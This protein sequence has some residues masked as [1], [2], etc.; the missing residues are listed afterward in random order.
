MADRDYYEL[1]GVERSATPEEIK[2]AY[3]KLALQYHPDR[4]PGN[5]EAEAK[6]KE[7][8]EAYEVLSD[9]EKRRRY[10]QFGHEGV[11]SSFGPGGFDFQRDFSHFDDLQEILG[12]LFGG[13]G[14]LFEEMFQSAGRRRTTRNGPQPGSDLQFEMDIDLEEALFGSKREVTLPMEE[15]CSRC[16]GTGVEPGS[17]VEICRRC[18]GNGVIVSGG[19]FFQIR[20]TCPECQGQGQTAGTVCRDCRGSGRRK[21][22][23]TLTITIPKGVFNGARLRLAGKGEPGTRGGPPGNLYIVLR[24]RPHPLFQWE[25]ADLYCE[26][27][28]PLETAALGGTIEVPTPDGMAEIKIEPG[29]QTG[30]VYRLKGKGMVHSGRHARGD[31]LVRMVVQVPVHLTAVQRR[32]L[33]ELQQQSTDAQYPALLDYRQKVDTFYQRQ[34]ELAG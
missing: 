14:G 4:N 7:I 22:R 29:T 23:R 28:L 16:G 33:R 32:L 8:S 24:V 17:K 19:G 31:L 30:R 10:D 3:R 6:F 26:V 34:R 2:K 25:D 20:Q 21:T 15:D 1:L 27:P 9:P 5:K 13:G 11:R 18:R 12:S